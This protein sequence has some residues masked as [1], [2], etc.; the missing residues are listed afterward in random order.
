MGP[1]ELSG[2][3]LL[4]ALMGSGLVEVLHVRLDDLVQLVGM[5]NEHVAECAGRILSSD[6]ILAIQDVESLPIEQTRSR[7]SVRA[8][9]QWVTGIPRQTV[10]MNQRCSGPHRPGSCAEWEDRGWDCRRSRLATYW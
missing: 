7:E 5:K 8:Q 9:P 4:D 1:G 2:H 10:V 6:W 3:A